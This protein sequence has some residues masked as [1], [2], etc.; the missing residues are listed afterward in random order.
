MNKPFT[1]LARTLLLTFLLATGGC[2]NDFSTAVSND[3]RAMY[4]CQDH[5][6]FKEILENKDSAFSVKCK[7]GLTV[8]WTNN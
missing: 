4:L 3:F 5:G 6:G 7:D 2:G 1:P 8:Y